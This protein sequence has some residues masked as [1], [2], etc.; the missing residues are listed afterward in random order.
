MKLVLC[1]PTYGP[2]QPEC[3]TSL[4]RAVIF[5]SR[6][7]DFEWIGDVSMD[8]LMWSK[9]RTLALK[10]AQELGA[11]GMLWVD[12]DM[13]IP[14]Q[15]FCQLVARGEDLVSALYFDRYAPY[16]AAAWRENNKRIET[17][18]HDL[19]P[20]H[21]FGFG[22]CFT[23]KKVM[24]IV[25]EFEFEEENGEDFQFCAKAM[26]LGITPML[27]SSIVCRHVDGLHSI[28]EMEYLLHNNLYRAAPQ[29][30]P[31]GTY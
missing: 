28:G 14:Q 5:A 20:V 9:S 29:L 27:D 31:D 24:E 25:G 22:C 11:D 16:R 21:G 17:W 13:I 10:S 1:N 8:R 2:V 6:H 4:V 26:A 12:S 19:E 7:R 23:S 3:K 15:A 30:P 18:T